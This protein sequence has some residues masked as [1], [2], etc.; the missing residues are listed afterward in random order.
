M[1]LQIEKIT[2]LAHEFFIKFGSRFTRKNTVQLLGQNILI[3]NKIGVR[4]QRCG[5][6]GCGKHHAVAVDDFMTHDALGISDF[7]H[8]HIVVALEQQ[9]RLHHQPFKRKIAATDQR[10]LDEP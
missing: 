5:L 2:A 3:A 9:L 6:N 1:P 4:H 7:R 8:I 10:H